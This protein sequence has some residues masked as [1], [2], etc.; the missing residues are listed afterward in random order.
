MHLYLRPVRVASPDPVGLVT[1]S[2]L[3]T[4]GLF[5]QG[6]LR[7][8][9]TWLIAHV[10]GV[11]ATGGYGAAVAVASILSLLWP[12]STGAAASKYIARA[13]GSADE[14]ELSAVVAHFRRRAGLAG[15]LVALLAVP[16]WVVV[17][18]GSTSGGLC[19]AA[20]T[21]AYSGYSFVR[22]VLFGSG[23]VG[24]A[25]VWD[26]ISST[27]GLAALGVFL[28]VGVR[29]PALVLPLAAAYGV[30]TLAGWPWTLPPA[31]DLARS[32]RRE[33]DRFVLIGASGTL[34]S[35]GFLQLAMVMARS[36]DKYQAG[37]FAAA[38]QT[39]TPAS[40]LAASLSLVLLPSLSES[41]G[42]GDDERFRAMADR[43]TRGLIVVMVAVFGGLA[44]ASVPVMT[45]LWPAAFDPRSPIFPILAMA[46]LA[47]NSSV[48]AVNALTALSTRWM[49]VTSVA[50]AAGLAVGAVVWWLGVGR[51][52]VVAVA[53]G[54]LVG[55]VVTNV[56]PLVVEW[57]VGHHRW[58]G[59]MA[60]TGVAIGAV[61]AGTV[62]LHRYSPNPWVDVVVAVAFVGA[63]VVARRGDLRRLGLKVPRR[64][65]NNPV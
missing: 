26:L 22:G 59:L 14:G 48:A 21:L 25:T 61:V 53:A 63:W 11:E 16:V 18:H 13:R 7:F 65:R 17:D 50:S 19:V 3:S 38:M 31:T 23:H 60:G 29:G 33:L 43:A 52:G 15:A 1:G 42:S 57:R 8:A 28:A 39:A 56:V 2:A 45:L 41:L 12:T 34:A 6:L 44:L 20:F 10:A 24:R 27:L 46:L 49:V 9:S 55:T 40:M 64:P 37:Q 4:L 5:A 47:S 62:A 54:Y 32:L 51:W 30:Y 35:T 36:T 58:G